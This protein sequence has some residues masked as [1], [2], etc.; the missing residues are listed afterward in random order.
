MWFLFGLPEH[1][2]VAV[3][4]VFSH[5]SGE[6]AI[7]FAVGLFEHLLHDPFARVSH[8]SVLPEQP[9]SDGFV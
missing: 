9:I 6:V 2:L 7:L 1:A 3:R 4:H 5:H 8:A